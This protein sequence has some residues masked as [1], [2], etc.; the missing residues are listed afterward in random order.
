[1]YVVVGLH[2]IRPE[3]IDEY[4]EQVS[5][6]AANSRTEPGCVRY[7]VLRDLDAPNVFALIEVFEDE[8]AFES[9]RA[10]AH[11]ERWMT[12]SAGWRVDEARVRHVMD[13]VSPRGE[14]Q[15]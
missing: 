3:H 8:A 9:H 14:P 2:T 13:F 15:W 10:A 4:V 12:M 11:Y 5:V 6:H 7:E 1:M